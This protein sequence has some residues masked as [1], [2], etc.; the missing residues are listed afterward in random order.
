V[1]EAP[2][3]GELEGTMSN[4][5]FFREIGDFERVKLLKVPNK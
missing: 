3:E 1:E 2:P 4:I 5:F